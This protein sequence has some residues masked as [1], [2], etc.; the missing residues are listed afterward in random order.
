MPGRYAI[1]FRFPPSRIACNPSWEGKTIESSFTPFK[2][3]Y[4]VMVGARL[5]GCPW[6]RVRSEVALCPNLDTTGVR[7]QDVE[8]RTRS[9]E[10]DVRDA[11]AGEVIGLD[12]RS[13]LRDRFSL[14]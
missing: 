9:Q 4:T 13:P 6:W 2:P 8:P 14:G 7:S 11:P 1:I 10:S 3:V 12:W 5:S